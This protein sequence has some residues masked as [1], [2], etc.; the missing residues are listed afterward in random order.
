MTSSLLLFLASLFTGTAAVLGWRAVQAGEKY[1]WTWFWMLLAF[2]CQCVVLGQRGVLRGH[3]PL[4]DLGEIL[5][6]LAWSLVIFYFVTGPTYRVSLLGLFSAPVVTVMQLVALIPGVMEVAPPRVEVLDPWNETHA[7]MS[8]LS[9]GAFALASIA[10][11]MFLVLNQKLK[12][13]QLGLGVGLFRGLPPVR[14]LVDS[15]V[16]LTWAGLVLLT[17][18]IVAGFNIVREGANLHLWIAVGVWVAYIILLGVWHAFGMTPRKMAM[19]VV[20][21]FVLSLLVFAR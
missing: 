5:V 17:V 1:R 6:F 18:G 4:G 14:S 20:V 19:S 13:H 15:V 11:V 16:R 8:V 21:L 12:S 10:G 3:C 7:A 9:Y 2:S